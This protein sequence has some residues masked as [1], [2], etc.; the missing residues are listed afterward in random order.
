MQSGNT[1]GQLLVEKSAIPTTAV[2]SCEKNAVG[3]QISL[4]TYL[5]SMP[6][7]QPVSVFSNKASFSASW[8]LEKLAVVDATEE[9]ESNKNLSSFQIVRCMQSAGFTAGNSGVIAG[10]SFRT[11]HVELQINLSRGTDIFPIGIARVALSGDEE[12]ETVVHV[13]VQGLEKTSRKRFGKIGKSNKKKRTSFESDPT[14]KWSLEDNATMKVGIQVIPQKTL[15]FGEEMETKKKEDELRQL[16]QQDDI[17]TLLLRIGSG[18]MG[19]KQEEKV[20]EKNEPSP[21][22]KVVPRVEPPKT[23]TTTSLAGILCGALPSFCGSTITPPAEPARIPA[24]VGG[25]NQ[26]LSILSSVSEST[27][28]M[29][30]YDDDGED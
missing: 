29:T 8:P 3:S 6:L 14:L 1:I 17:A 13:P 7:K 18:K 22:R 21:D 4:Q 2:V 20:L 5:P 30:H 10:T 9:N 15:E 12:Q 11:Q 25:N 26:L 24:V 27:D 19:V 23:T 16:L 28:G